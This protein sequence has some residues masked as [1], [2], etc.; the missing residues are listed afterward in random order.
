MCV[1]SVSL[2]V[3]AWGD[4]T[5]RAGRVDGG[6][7]SLAFVPDARPGDHVLAHLGIPVEVVVPA[8]DQGEAP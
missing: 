2:L 1:G 4:A 5:A 6:A 7:V 3:D 8:A